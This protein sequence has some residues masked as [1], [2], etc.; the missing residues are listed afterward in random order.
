MIE[1]GSYLQLPVQRLEAR[2]SAV[3]CVSKSS[4]SLHPEL[5]GQLQI[6]GG[7]VQR[8]RTA[9]IKG[10]RQRKMPLWLSLQTGEAWEALMES[11]VPTP[12]TEVLRGVGRW[13]GCATLRESL[14][15]CES[16]VLHL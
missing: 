15:P 10:Q 4:R 7:G 2:P 11:N 3:C 9:E 8:P 5:L 12:R 14:N 13:L 1:T 6:E 16:Q